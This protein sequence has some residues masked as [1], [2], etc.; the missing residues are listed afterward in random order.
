MTS[1][2][3]HTDQLRA[4]LERALG[5]QYEIVRLLG[6]GGMGAVYLGLERFLERQ[7]AIKILPAE[8]ARDPEMRERFRREARTAAQLTHPNI[9]P[10]HSYGE[11]EGMPFFVMGFVRGEGLAGRLARQGRLH[12]DEVRR[13]LSEI[14]DA[15][16]YAHRR[17]VVHRDIKPDN[18]LI[19][20]ETGRALLADFGVARQA[21]NTS[22]LTV[23]GSIVGTPYYM[24][25]E[26]A[27]ADKSLDGRSDLYS[28]GVV[29]YEL[30]AGRRPFEAETVQGILTQHV[31][32]TPPSLALAAPEA[33]P[34]LVQAIERCLLKDAD[35]R[36]QDGKALKDALN[37]RDDSGLESQM[38]AGAEGLPSVGV[39]G[40]AIVLGLTIPVLFALITG[41]TTM[42]YIKPWNKWAFVVGALTLPVLLVLNSA[43]PARRVGWGWRKILRIAFLEPHSWPTW[44]PRALRRPG[45]VWDRL[46]RL[47]R[48]ARVLQGVIAIGLI[49]MVTGSILIM[50]INSAPGD[51]PP[52][53][54]VP[55]ALGT[56]LV[57]FILI[58]L[59][60]LGAIGTVH[61]F[62]QRTNVSDKDALKLLSATNTSTFWQR[63]DIR[64]LLL[65]APLAGAAVGE[66]RT[67]PELLA[68]IDGLAAELPGNAM[69]GEAVSAARRL[70]R[71]LAA[72]ER[73]IVQLD[74]DFDPAQFA[75]VE[76]QLTGLN[77]GEDSGSRRQMRELLEGQRQLLQKLAD[78]RD[79][80][81]RRQEHLIGLLRT[82]WLQLAS[83]R[84]GIAQERFEEAAVSGKVRDVCQEIAAHVAATEEVQASMA[85]LRSTQ[86]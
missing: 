74:K 22:T 29:G 61:W 38:P 60:F 3:L 7:V 75:Q 71:A 19:E 32:N 84:A 18:I 45:S 63:P 31:L 39:K 34:L 10:L 2:P 72:I 12:P 46:P 65:A 36:W 73:E 69:A 53:M 54:A 6:R 40:M 35:R 43:L 33:P 59:P 80:V 70:S 51:L 27:T 76:R 14:A 47:L 25:P 68:R 56:L 8:A 67:V 20:E 57:G 44:W 50:K 9:V 13:I 66:P 23:Q 82:L 30:L 41:L 78:Q 4:A 85:T 24:S 37:W 42:T 17:G 26:Q 1:A 11:A 83:L 55:V 86:D 64:H 49:A 28:L 77:E 58:V 81:G 52:G 79:S 5:N 48:V 15:L 16:D 21:A 62:A